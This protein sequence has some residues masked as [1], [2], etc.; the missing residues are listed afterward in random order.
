MY[1]MM[2]MKRTVSVAEARDELPSL[3]DDVERGD[4][5][6]VTRR[7]KPVGVLVPYAK[8]VDARK[9]SFAE[10]LAKWRTRRPKHLDG[11]EFRNLRDR[12]PGKR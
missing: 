11:T 6:L 1:I 3:L 12:S 2:Y 7:G 8:Y 9:P 10:L 4:E 5:V